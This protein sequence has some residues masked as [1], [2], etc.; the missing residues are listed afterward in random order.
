M[1][2]IIKEPNEILHKK[3]EPV[4]DFKEAKKI[5]GDLLQVMKSIFLI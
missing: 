1:Q 4:T 2:E 5:A 3:C